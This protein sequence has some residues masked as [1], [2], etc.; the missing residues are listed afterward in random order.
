M[1]DESEFRE[2]CDD[3]IYVNVYINM[4][5]STDQLTNLDE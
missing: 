2:G 4:E 3:V 5:E 1:F